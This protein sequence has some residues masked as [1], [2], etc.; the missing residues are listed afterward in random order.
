MLV[1]KTLPNP[2]NNP[3]P[4]ADC[5][6]TNLSTYSCA[7]QD[8]FSDEIIRSYD[9]TTSYLLCWFL[10]KEET[11]NC[12]NLSSDYLKYLSNPPNCSSCEVISGNIASFSSRNI[13]QNDF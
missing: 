11:K 9:H 2:H 10:Y 6:R 5:Y 4:R 13:D 1:S 7:D 3:R 12:Y 8:V